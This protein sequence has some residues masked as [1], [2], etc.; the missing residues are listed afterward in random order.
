MMP[1]SGGVISNQLETHFHRFD[2]ACQ[3]LVI[4]NRDASEA[5]KDWGR[6]A[7]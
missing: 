5:L 6:K 4:N 3:A 2:N 1:L 7:P